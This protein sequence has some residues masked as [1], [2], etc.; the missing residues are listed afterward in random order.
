MTRASVALCALGL[1]MVACGSARPA[2]TPLTVTASGGPTLSGKDVS[3]TSFH[4]HPVVL[5]FWASWCGPCH[6]EQPAL[7]TAYTQWSARGVE[8]L[9]VDLRDGTKD[10][11]SFQSQLKV[12]YPSIA[13]TQ[14]TLAVDY[15]IPSAP[16][17]VFLDAR[18]KVADVVLGALGTMSVADF[19]AELTSL[20][21]GQSA[22]A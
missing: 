14:A 4:G 19:N 10:A 2:A 22:S 16:A 3:I 11:L 7:N 6:D 21:G 12:P 1:C 20:L 15:R 8:F 17:L 9:G 5:I 13:D 18:G